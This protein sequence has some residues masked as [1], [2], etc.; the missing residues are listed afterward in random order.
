MKLSKEKQLTIIKALDIDNPDGI[1][2]LIRS[3]IQRYLQLYDGDPKVNKYGRAVEF[4]LN[5]EDISDFQKTLQE[6]NP[7][8]SLA[9]D[10]CLYGDEETEDGE[11]YFNFYEDVK[12]LSKLIRQHVII[13]NEQITFDID[14]ILIELDTAV[15]YY[16]SKFTPISGYYFYSRNY[17]GIEKAYYVYTKLIGDKQRVL[18]T[19]AGDVECIT[20][21]TREEWSRI[22][23]LE[24]DD[25]KY[26]AQSKAILDSAMKG[27]H[28]PLLMVEHLT[29]DLNSKYE[30]YQ[31]DFDVD[32]DALITEYATPHAY[33]KGPLYIKAHE[34]TPELARQQDMPALAYEIEKMEQIYKEEDK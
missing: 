27:I 7:D 15:N 20:T 21:V 26:K 24:Y 25:E 29:E 9:C 10:C 23:M 32:W 16:L 3:M 31:Y 12:D 18:N 14:P 22:M 28:L 8:Q 13:K 4:E 11:I 34:I 30:C 2:I 5:D 17:L 1:Y 33:Q 6:F 19:L